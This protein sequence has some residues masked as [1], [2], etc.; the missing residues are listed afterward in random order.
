M[1]TGHYQRKYKDFTGFRFP[2][3]RLVVQSLNQRVEYKDA[4]WN[5]LCDCGNTIPVAQGHLKNGHTQ[6]CGCLHV[7]RTAAASLTHGETRKDNVNPVYFVWFAMKQRCLNPAHPNYVHY[8]GRGIKVCDRWLDPEHGLKNFLE[9][10][11]PRPEGLTL[12][13]FP[14]NDG[15]YEPGNVRWATWVEQANN[16]KRLGD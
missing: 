5:C 3:S 6:S 15:N 16:K 4:I 14:D 12:D 10:M 8:G 2:G 7:E 13:R 1:P 11:G 9:D